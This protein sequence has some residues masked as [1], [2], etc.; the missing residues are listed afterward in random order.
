MSKSSPNK[1]LL[2]SVAKGAKTGENLSPDSNRYAELIGSLFYLYTT[3][4]PD[5]AFSVSMLSRYMACPEEDHTRAAQGMLLYLP[6]A[7]RLAVAYGRYKPPQEYFDASWAEDNDVRRS[8][9]A[10]SSTST[11]GRSRGRSSASRRWR[12]RRLRPST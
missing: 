4:R 6:G 7:T 3:T 5:I 12:R 10:A 2:V 11:A 8:T 9:T 1:T